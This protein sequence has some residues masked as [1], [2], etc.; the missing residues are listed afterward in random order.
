MKL[1]QSKFV[2]KNRKNISKNNKRMLEN[3]DILS[4]GKVTVAREELIKLAEWRKTVRES[5][6]QWRESHER[7]K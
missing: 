2:K 5:I 4:N 7:F 1:N 3:A 6:V